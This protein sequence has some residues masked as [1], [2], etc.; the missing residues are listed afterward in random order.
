VRGGRRA[1]V[2]GRHHLIFANGGMSMT[3]PVADQAFQS[4]DARSREEVA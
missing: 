1:V 4:L 2:F 3:K